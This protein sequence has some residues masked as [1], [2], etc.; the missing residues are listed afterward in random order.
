MYVYVSIYAYT[1]IYVCSNIPSNFSVGLIR[2]VLF[3]ALPQLA[4]IGG[5]AF[6]PVH[7]ACLQISHRDRPR[8]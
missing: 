5:T 7:R 3:M 4:H 1:D 6:Y 2:D 8:L